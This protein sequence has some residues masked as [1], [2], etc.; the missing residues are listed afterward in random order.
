MSLVDSL[1]RRANLVIDTG[2]SYLP[3]DTVSHLGNASTELLRAARALLDEQIL[4]N[5]RHVA[6]AEEIRLRR[7]AAGAPAAPGLTVDGPSRP[8]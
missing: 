8:D 5:G 2:L 3:A 4:W 7:R 6:R 1:R